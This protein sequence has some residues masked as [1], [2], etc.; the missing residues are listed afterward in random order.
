MVTALCADS[1]AQLTVPQ[2]GEPYDRTARF[3]KHV[4]EDCAGAV[5]VVTL[6]NLKPEDISRL[7]DNGVDGFEIINCGH[8]GLLPDLRRELL[9][10][11]RSRGV[12]LVGVTDWHGWGGLT[13]AWTVIR[14]PGA[15][16][17][18]HQEIGAAAIAKLR[19]RNGTDVIPVVAGYFGVPSPARAIF[20]P[21]V[22]AIRY[23]RELSPARVLSW[24]IWVWA[25]FAL[26]VLLRGAGLSPGKVLISL[27]LGFIGLGMI[28]AGLSLM[29]G[30]AGHDAPFSFRMALVTLAAGVATLLVALTSGLLIWRKGRA[31]NR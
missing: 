21:V 29:G 2:I 14:M 11:R 3:T 13:R 31:I 8:P 19:E 18:S 15:S 27:L 17:L 10:A 16:S 9:D 5:I 7:M 25:V 28:F 20:S 1:H 12:A 30:A 22:E 24:W 6:N 26:W 23:A 4:H